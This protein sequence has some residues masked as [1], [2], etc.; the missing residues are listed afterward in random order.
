MVAMRSVKIRTDNYG[1]YFYYRY[2][3]SK[4]ASTLPFTSYTVLLPIY[5]L[6][7]ICHYL[8]QSPLFYLYLHVYCRS[9]H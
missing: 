4:Q 7:G 2:A 6:H 9:P 1:F 3:S 8:K 5:F